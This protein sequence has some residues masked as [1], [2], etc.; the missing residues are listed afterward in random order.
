MKGL[1]N[2]EEKEVKQRNKSEKGGRSV[3]MNRREQRWNEGKLIV[4][5]EERVLRKRGIDIEQ[6]RQQVEN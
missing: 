5:I 6:S 4:E 2:E 1:M 3:V